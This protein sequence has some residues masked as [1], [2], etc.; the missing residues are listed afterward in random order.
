MRV[1]LLLTLVAVALATFACTGNEPAPSPTP[2]VESTTV[3]TPDIPAAV[4]AGIAATKEAEA[5]IEATVTARV[6]AT[7]AAE[8]TPA[9]TPKPPPT[10][11][12]TPPPPTATPPPT[13]TPQPTIYP[14]LLPD[15]EERLIRNVY[16]CIHSGSEFAEG[17]Y[18]GFFKASEG[19]E[20]LRDLALAVLGDWDTFRS[21]VIFGLREDPSFAGELAGLADRIETECLQLGAEPT[22]RSQTSSQ[23]DREALVALYH[24]TDGPNWRNNTNWLSDAPL[25]EWHRVSTDSAGSVIGLGLGRNRLSDTAGV[26]QPRQPGIAGPRPE[27]IERGD[28]AGVGQP[29]PS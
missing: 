29:R 8:P 11:S 10:P 2:T 15:E 24:A 13:L 14:T 12:A 7:R 6:E 3:P 19:N 22:P 23:T 21:Q 20:S 4:E 28:T 18:K 5:S 17:F 1:V 26:G 25:D 16:D 9:P 27:P